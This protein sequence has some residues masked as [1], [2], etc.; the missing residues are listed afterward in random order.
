MSCYCAKTLR[1]YIRLIV[2]F[3]N[4]LQNNLLADWLILYF[5]DFPFNTLEIVRE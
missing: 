5:S 1:N 2:Q 3:F 4:G